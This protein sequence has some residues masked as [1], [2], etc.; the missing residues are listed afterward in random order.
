MRAISYSI[1]YEHSAQGESVT[2]LNLPRFCTRRRARPLHR[3]AIYVTFSKLPRFA[4]CDS[5]QFAPV[6][7]GAAGHNPEMSIVWLAPLLPSAGGAPGTRLRVWAAA[8]G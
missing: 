6:S 8:G 4:A 5:S 1:A 3:S 7:A 2:I